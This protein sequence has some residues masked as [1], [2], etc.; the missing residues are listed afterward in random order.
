[1][2]HVIPTCGGENAPPQVINNLE[3]H[4]DTRVTAQ[5]RAAYVGHHLCRELKHDLQDPSCRYLSCF[6]AVSRLCYG[7]TAL[8]VAWLC[9]RVS[10]DR[11]LEGQ[12]HDDFN[13][14]QEFGSEG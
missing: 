14:M 9:G 4:R 8:A 12:N 5:I 1:M 13:V 10:R 3:E 6:E 2:T 7:E 11:E